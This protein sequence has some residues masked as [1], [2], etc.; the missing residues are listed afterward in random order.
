MRT[1]KWKEERK[2]II[3]EHKTNPLGRQGKILSEEYAIGGGAD[4]LREE[5]QG[6]RSKGVSLRDC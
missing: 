4:Y 1:D 3:E 2:W 6:F 5:K